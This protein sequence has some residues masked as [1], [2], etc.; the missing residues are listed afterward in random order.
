MPIAIDAL[1]QNQNALP[2][3]PRVLDDLIASF[4]DPDA[5]VESIARK[6]AQDPVLSAKLLRLANSA[7][8]HVSRSVASVDDAVRMLGFVTV[9]SLVIS[10][11]LVGSFKSVPGIDLKQFWR[12]SLETAVAAK[13]LARQAHDNTDLAFTVGLMHA[14]GQLVMRAGARDQA[15]ELDTQ[16]GPYHP[17]RIAAERAALGY[18]YT[19]VG[20]A[21][22][23][24]WKFPLI[25]AE[26]LRSFPAPLPI[27]PL[28]RVAG[29]VHLA[30]WKVQLAHGDSD[31]PFPAEV[32]A[33]L[34]LDEAT[35]AQMPPLGELT[36]GL[37]ELVN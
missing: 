24:A 26:T 5:S 7:Y 2:A 10:A 34:G 15:L 13:W 3:A 17:D 31:A 37:E 29:V 22:A 35:C 33:G 14:L 25:F 30:V 4:D 19:D 16:A 21:L 32:A 6:L 12:Y 36:A 27:T 1:L 9:R 8:Y 23:D 28:N 11:G 20:A 18:A